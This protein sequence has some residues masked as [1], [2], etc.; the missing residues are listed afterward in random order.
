MKEYIFLFV[1]GHKV[2]LGFCASKTHLGGWV[3]GSCC[4]CCSLI[5]PSESALI[6][7]FVQKPGEPVAPGG[8]EASGRAG[9]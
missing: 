9:L 6:F 7:T 3:P 5:C 8:A 4:P 2:P 1:K